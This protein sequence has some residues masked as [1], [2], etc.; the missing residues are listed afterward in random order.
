MALDQHRQEAVGQ[1]LDDLDRRQRQVADRQ[2]QRIGQEIGRDRRDDAEL[3]RAG[4]RVPGAARG[5]G[6]I[7][8]RGEGAAGVLD[9]RGRAACDAHRTALALEHPDA[10]FL[11]ELED[12]AAEGRLTDVAGR[13]G[14][15]EMAVIG[16]GDDIVQVS[17]VH[18]ALI[19]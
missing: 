2:G 19:R 3:E 17:E 7:G 9:D 10:Q 13:G 16:D 11:L 5:E 6:D 15:A 8:G 18:G 14:P 12:L 1:V 4:E